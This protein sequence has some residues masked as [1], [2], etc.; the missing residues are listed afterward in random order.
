MAE[1]GFV[2]LDDN[3]PGLGLS[4]KTEFLNDF[5]IIG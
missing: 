1:N 3:T 4:L 5:N 2:Q